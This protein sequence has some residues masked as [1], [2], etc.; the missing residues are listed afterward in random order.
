MFDAQRGLKASG[1]RVRGGGLLRLSVRDDVWSRVHLFE[2]VSSACVEGRTTQ[3]PTGLVAGALLG[4]LLTPAIRG[5]PGTPW[6]RL[7]APAAVLTV[8]GCAY[9]YRA[10]VE[11][12][13]WRPG[14]A[15]VAGAA[16]CSAS[17]AADALVFLEVASMRMEAALRQPGRRLPFWR[18]GDPMRQAPSP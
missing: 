12:P 8:A 1:P 15:P 18:R 6:T 2:E 9:L 4:P 13:A 7:A 17:D 5:I 11:V 3:V 16:V 10:P 14:G